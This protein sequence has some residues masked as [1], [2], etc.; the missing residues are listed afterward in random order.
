MCKVVTFLVIGGYL[1]LFPFD[2]SR[3]AAVSF[4]ANGHASWLFLKMSIKS[5]YS[6]FY[7]KTLVNSQLV[8]GGWSL[9]NNLTWNTMFVFKILNANVSIFSP[10]LSPHNH[11]LISMLK[12]KRSLTFMCL[13]LLAACFV[14]LSSAASLSHFLHDALSFFH[15]PAFVLF[16]ERNW[17]FRFRLS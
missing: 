3:Y 6:H 10:T 11:T 4:L 7:I 5:L 12:E 2:F 15:H 8:K 1:F 13:L 17:I 16:R 9:W 14:P